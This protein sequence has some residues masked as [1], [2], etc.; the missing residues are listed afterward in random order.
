MSSNAIIKDCTAREKATLHRATYVLNNKFKVISKNFGDN[1][2]TNIAKGDWPEISNKDRI[3]FFQNKNIKSLT[4]RRG[5][6]G[7]EKN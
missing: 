1:L 7:S 5:K 3:F 2:V 4:P 6:F